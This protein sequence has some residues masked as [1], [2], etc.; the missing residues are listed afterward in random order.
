MFT[1]GNRSHQL[2]RALSHDAVINLLTPY[3]GTG[4]QVYLY[5]WYTSTALFQELHGMRFGACG[6]CRDNRTG[7][8]YPFTKVNDMPRNAKRGTIE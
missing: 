5:N 4:Y 2:K 6:T 8:G 1:Q 7:T 3:L